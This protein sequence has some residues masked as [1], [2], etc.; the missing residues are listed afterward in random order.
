MSQ[1]PSSLSWTLPVQQQLILNC[2]SEVNKAAE[3]SRVVTQR[4]YF[5]Y[6][7]VNLATVITHGLTKPVFTVPALSPPGYNPVWSCW[8]IQCDSGH[9][10]G[11]RIYGMM[12]NVSSSGICES[13]ALLGP[14][15]MWVCLCLSCCVNIRICLIH[16]IA[17]ECVCIVG[18]FASAYCLCMY[19][20][21]A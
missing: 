7:F 6:L 21:C 5:L 1:I 19:W 15:Y 3:Q 13:A 10:L 8:E 18:G 17:G 20:L 14:R 16:V 4:L 11:S 2:S 9:V 12:R